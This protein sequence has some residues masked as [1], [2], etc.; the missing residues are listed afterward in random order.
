VL[1]KLFHDFERT[2]S[3]E[4]P[5]TTGRWRNMPFSVVLDTPYLRLAH[6][7]AEARRKFQPAPS[8]PIETLNEGGLIVHVGP[9]DFSSTDSIELVVIKRGDSLIRP[10][11]SE[12]TPEVMQ[13]AMG[14]SRATVRGRFHFPM[15]AFAPTG[16]LT[17]VLVGRSENFEI[18]LSSTELATLR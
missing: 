17:L 3:G 11:K 9:K 7:A 13:N 1:A 2:R 4:R 5:A 10:L 18:P 14:A 12:L 15:D 16:P 8:P 6:L